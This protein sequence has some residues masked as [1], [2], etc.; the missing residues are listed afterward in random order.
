MAKKHPRSYP[1]EF[2]Q[3]ILDL[4]AAGR[5]VEELGR[6]FDVSSQTIRNWLKQAALDGGRRTDG[7]TTA[8]RDEL[9]R[10]RK[11]NRQLKTEREILSKAA[12]WFAR[13][14]DSIPSRNS[15]S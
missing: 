7:L 3:T 11:E 8:E 6:Q 5:D 15:N 10:L 1:L 4:A 12:A 13:E 9:G 2:R 14:T